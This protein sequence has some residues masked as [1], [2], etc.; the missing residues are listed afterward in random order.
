[1]DL[2]LFK[3][4]SRVTKLNALIFIKHLN[5]I[6]CVLFKLIIAVRNKKY[7]FLFILCTTKMMLNA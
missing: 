1:M 4:T 2:I 3:R 7:N 5:S 6:F